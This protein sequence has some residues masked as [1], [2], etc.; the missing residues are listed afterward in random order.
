MQAV[1]AAEVRRDRLTAQIAAMLLDWTLAPVVAALQTMRGMALVNAVTL[2]AELGDLS[3]FADPR[4]LM[5]YLGLVPAEHSS[6]ASIRRGGL[7]KAGNGAA[8]RLL[9]EAAWC[10]RFPARVSRELLR[11]EEQRKPIR[12]IAWKA[13]LRL[14]ARY[15]KLARAGKPVNVVTAAIARELAGFVWAI[16]RRVPPA[17]NFLHGHRS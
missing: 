4:L 16:A 3:R 1:E 15:R 14:C 6:G 2:I 11:Q 12:E 5:A 8:R 7:T 17:A 13:Q 9:I 10:Y